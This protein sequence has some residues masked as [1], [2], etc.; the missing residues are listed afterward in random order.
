MKKND[1]TKSTTSAG[2]THHG[3]ARRQT[4]SVERKHELAGRDGHVV[5]VDQAELHYSGVVRS[6][7]IGHQETQAGT[8]LD[9]FQIDWKCFENTSFYT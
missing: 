7:N 1:K 5:G 2:T 4:E 9:T 8:V 3:S 6:Q